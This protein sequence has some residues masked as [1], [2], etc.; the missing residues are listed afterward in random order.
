M[1]VMIITIII[2]GNLYLTSLNTYILSFYFFNIIFV[3][4]KITIYIH[5]QG[6]S[7]LFI[8]KIYPFLSP[9]HLT[10]FTKLRQSPIIILLFLLLYYY[11]IIISITVLLL[12]LLL[13]FLLLFHSIVIIN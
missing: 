2:Y 3:L 4:F 6:I 1:K 5:D 10:I 11:Y 9:I 12:L 13:L 8:M 7:A